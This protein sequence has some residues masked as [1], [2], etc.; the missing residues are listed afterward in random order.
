MLGAVFQR[1]DGKLYVFVAETFALLKC[2]KYVVEHGS[3]ICG[4]KHMQ[5]Q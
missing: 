5:I 3:Q 4:L 1:V 2:L